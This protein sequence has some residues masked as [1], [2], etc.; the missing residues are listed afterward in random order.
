MSRFM[1]LAALILLIVGTVAAEP[2][3]VDGG[4]LRSDE[5]PAEIATPDDAPPEDA[6][7]PAEEG[8]ANGGTAWGLYA[9]V[10][11]CGLFALAGIWGWLRWDV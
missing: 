9:A 2:K 3:H 10:A 5:V 8:A 1:L 6:G 4:W 7:E 11:L